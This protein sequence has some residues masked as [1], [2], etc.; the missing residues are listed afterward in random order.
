LT[1]GGRLRNVGTTYAY[2]ENNP[3]SWRDPLGLTPDDVVQLACFAKEQNPDLPIPNG[4]RILIANLP[5]GVAGETSASPFTSTFTV[6]SMYAEV[7]TMDQLIDLYNTILHES[8]HVSQPWYERAFDVPDAE[9]E[10]YMG[11][12]NRTK[13]SAIKQIKNGKYKCGCGK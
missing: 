2:A 5:R 6:S 11:A 8:I 12:G 13:L 10:A 1:I 4:H 3:M 7:L 9:A